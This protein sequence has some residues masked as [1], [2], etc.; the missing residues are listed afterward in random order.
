MLWKKWALRL[1]PK[2]AK[3]STLPVVGNYSYRIQI[4]NAYLISA[5]PDYIDKQLAVEA[6]FKWAPFQK[7]GTRN[8]I[9]ES[10]DDT[11]QLG[12][13]TAFT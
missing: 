9:E 12:T 2:K 10:C 8:K 3:A 6:T 1:K 11:A 7:D 5:K 4:F 13:V